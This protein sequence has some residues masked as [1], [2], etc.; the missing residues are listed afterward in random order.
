MFTAFFLL[1]TAAI[2]TQVLTTQNALA[3]N[4]THLVINEFDSNPA[5]TDSRK[6]WIELYNPT[7]GSVDLTGWTIR[8]NSGLTI[9]I[10]AR[11]SLP[12]GAYYVLN[13]TSGNLNNDNIQ[14]TLRNPALIGVDVTPTLS[15]N[16]DNGFAW[17]RFPNGIDTDTTSDWSFR[18][19]TI[20]ASNGK[21]ASSISIAVN[22][23]QI[24]VFESIT[25]TGS[26]NAS[27]VANVTLQFATDTTFSTLAVVTTNSNGAYSYS[28]PV[29]QAGTYR[30]RATWPGD[31]LRNGATSSTLTLQVNKRSSS[32]SLQATPGNVTVGNNVTVTGTLTPTIAS[33]SITLTYTSENGTVTTKSATTFTNGSFRD[34]FSPQ[35]D[36]DWTVRASWAGDVNT[37]GATSPNVPFHARPRLS[38][39]L[40]LIIALI[41]VAVIPPIAVA[42]IVLTGRLGGATQRASG[43]PPWRFGPRPPRPSPRPSP[44]LSIPQADLKPLKVGNGALCPICF[45][46][47]TYR[48]QAYSWLCDNC[49]RSYAA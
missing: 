34:V 24:T 13:V 7:S 21:L 6:E 22:P 8:T 36:G 11:T 39:N 26:I 30:L 46:P 15:D 9:I 3:I 40:G 17:A 28:A 38:G 2:W 4:G 37:N 35:F 45:R 5:G 33:A 42:G 44:M 1:L 29:N 16:Q 48:P 31:Q 20:G 14:L 27:V 43:R 47:M 12:S 25:V 49:G 19:G 18:Q 23:S 32:L 41:A 10:P